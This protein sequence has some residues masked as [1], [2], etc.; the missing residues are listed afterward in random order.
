MKISFHTLGCKVNQYETEALIACF[1]GRGYEVAKESEDADVYVINTCTVTA[2]AEKKSRQLIRRAK[3]RNPDCIIAVTGCYAEVAPSEVSC[4]EGVD[5]MCGNSNKMGLPQYLESFIYGTAM[6][7]SAPH[8]GYGIV[9]TMESKTRAFIKV[10]DGCNRFCSYCIIPYARG[11]VSSRPLD[12]ITEE[13]GALI[14][15]GYKEIV[16]TGVNTALYGMDTSLHNGI[17]SIIDELSRIPGDF[18][19]RLSSLEPTVINADYVKKLLKYDK[20]CPHLHLSLQSGSDK[21]LKAMNRRYSIKEYMEIVDALKSYDPDYGISTDIIAGFPG[22]KEDEFQKSI[23]ML[24][25]VKFCK[26]HVFSYSNRRGTAAAGMEEQVCG[27][28]IKSRA[29]RLIS[30]GETSMQQFFSSNAGKTRRVLV[31]EFLEGEGAYTGYTDNYIK[32]YINKN[33]TDKMVLNEF[34]DVKLTGLYKDGMKAEI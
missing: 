18:R 15:N 12:S 11:E 32:V 29:G 20:L 8:Q 1:K 5:V 6:V 16:L 21:V 13:A 19:I 23:Y 14:K 24:V 30:S 34:A 28:E 3:K 4:I 2:L 31:E 17:E 33:Y 9:E 27:R 7:D 22:E 26:V 25:K 10:Q